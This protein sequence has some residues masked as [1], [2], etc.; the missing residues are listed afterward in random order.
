MNN[1]LIISCFFCISIFQSLTL[2]G[3]SNKNKDYRDYFENGKHLYKSGNYKQAIDAYSK[4]LVA[5]PEFLNSY[6]ERAKAYEAIDS[7]KLAIDDL[8][9]YSG[10]VTKTDYKV[11]YNLARLFNKIYNYKNAIGHATT[12]I[13]TKNNYL[14]AYTEKI[15]AYIALEN[16]NDALKTS[17]DALDINRC[18][19]NYFTL[20][21]VYFLLKSYESALLN[22][23]NAIKKNYNYE[24]AYIY[25]AMALTELGKPEN[26]NSAY[27]TVNIA[28][29]KNKYCREC[30]LVRSKVLHDQNNI[31]PAI[32]DLNTVINRDPDNPDIDKLIFT[33]GIYHK[34]CLQPILGIDDF[35]EVLRMNPDY[36]EAYYHRGLL[37]N[38]IDKKQNAIDDFESYLCNS[39]NNSNSDPLIL[40]ACK[41]SIYALKR[42]VIKP[43]ININEPVQRIDY[44]LDINKSREEF[45]IK[46][47]IIDDNEIRSIKINGT[48]LNIDNKL[49]KDK[50]EFESDY[51]D[52]NLEEI[53]IEVTDVYNNTSKNTFTIRRTEND[54]P[55]INMLRPYSDGDNLYIEGD[56]PTIMLEGNVNDENLIKSFKLDS[57]SNI[58]YDPI[59]FN[60]LWWGGIE[61]SNRNSITLSVEDY[62]GNVT[63]KSYNIIRNMT[64]LGENNPMGNTWALLFANSNYKYYEPLDGPKVDAMQIQK[65]LKNDYNFQN[66]IIQNDLNKN[67][68]EK[69]FQVD[70]RRIIEYYNINSLLIWYAGHGLYQN[71]ESYWLPV[72]AQNNTVTSYFSITALRSHLVPYAKDLAHLLIV[73]DACNSGSSFYELY[74]ESP[75]SLSCN[76]T[77]LM[78]KKSYQVLT[79]SKSDEV[80][81]DQSKF[82]QIFL[83][84]LNSEKTSCISVNKIYKELKNEFD[85]QSIQTPQLG[86]IRGMSDQNG[87]FFFIKQEKNDQ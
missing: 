42:E 13:N 22:L 73:S 28:I 6:L 37:Y 12:A 17:Q 57:I 63:I 83:D 65:T 76:N 33:R 78:T 26:L 67:D 72:D 85:K 21:K 66:V 45:K 23:N 10:K 58:C 4:T 11:H 40:Q 32:N 81:S 9:A 2:F 34:E 31:I 79:S 41:D 69:Y 59:E 51:L 3:Q 74:R 71:D 46:G 82:V 50:W 44:T 25:K 56:P 24:D 87:T 15:N 38:E 64:E 49:M 36:I 62:F 61:I 35:N 1:N 43:V 60:P 8:L 18:D 7:I 48:E 86:A 30:L 14:P 77:N 20:G 29:N 84:V 52:A 68:F 39:K 75:Q 16:Y 55:I 5:K 27:S 70:L 19:A 53:I 47:K 80:S 54:P